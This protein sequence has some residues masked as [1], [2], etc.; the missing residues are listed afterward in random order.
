MISKEEVIELAE[1]V[2]AIN[3]GTSLTTVK[4]IKIYYAK[5]YNT[6]D[7]GQ[8]QRKV[9]PERSKC[10]TCIMDQLNA[11]RDWV[12]YP[13][14]KTKFIVSKKIKEERLEVCYNCKHLK[15]RAMYASTCGTLYIGGKVEG[16][17]LCGCFVH[18][19]AEITNEQC[20][21]GKWDVT[22]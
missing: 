2:P 3:K 17:E 6:N 11:V 9:Y 22:D 14:L 8:R 15:K 16:G 5:L 4:L 19:K 7:Y 13:P 20:P 1:R 10:Y 21:L 12:G 18:A